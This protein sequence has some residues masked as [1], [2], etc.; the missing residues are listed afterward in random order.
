MK[1][2][3]AAVLQCSDCSPV[4]GDRPNKEIKCWT[5]GQDNY[6]PSGST[7]SLSDQPSSDGQQSG[8]QIN[9]LIS[10]MD[11]VNLTVTREKR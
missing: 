1:A 7:L 10:T 8:L 4:S 9:V 2:C 6:N 5:A 11:P 3:S